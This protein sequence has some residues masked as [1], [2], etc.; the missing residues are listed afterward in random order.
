MKKFTCLALTIL[1]FAAGCRFASQPTASPVADG[2]VPQAGDYE[3]SLSNEGDTRTVVLHLPPAYD[4]TT[5][6]PLIIVL[7]GGAGNGEQI[8]RLTQMDED[9]DEYGFVVAYPD[10]S[11]RLEEILFTWNA[12]HCCG[13]ALANQS[14]DVGLIESLIDNLVSHY[15]IDPARVYITGISNGGMMAYRAGAELADKVAGIAPIAGSLGGQVT[16]NSQRVVPDAPASPVAVI[17]FHGM[18]DEHVLYE[19]GNAPMAIE[20]GRVDLSVAESVGFWVEANGCDPQPASETQ[21]DRNIVIET[22]S[23]CEGDA[24]VVLVTIVDGGHA[25]PGASRGLV[26]DQPTQ[27]ISANELM[28][29]F[30][31]AHQKE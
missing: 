26:S 19:G 4:G 20:D 14:D 11:G 9:A 1:L 27:D 8:Q 24:D 21:A 3:L 16:A 2:G 30:F 31:L 7:H 28:L 29:E 12:G 15:A 10:G 22:Y 17:A 6:L 18:E 25:W 13:Y 5:Q 23:G